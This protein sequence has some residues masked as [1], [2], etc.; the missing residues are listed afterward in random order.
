[1]YIYILKRLYLKIPNIIP[2]TED[3]LVKMHKQGLQLFYST[4]IDR[5]IVRTTWG[6][7]P[8]RRLPQSVH[9]FLHFSLAKSVHTIDSVAQAKDITESALW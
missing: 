7:S 8:E 4:T 9:R 5:P 1:M 2:V 3:R 6:L